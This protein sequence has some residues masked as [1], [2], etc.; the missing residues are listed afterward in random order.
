[1]VVILVARDKSRHCTHARSRCPEARRVLTYSGDSAV[2]E[3][4][5]VPV[6]PFLQ[7]SHDRLR[8]M[9]PQETAT[10]GICLKGC[11]PAAFELRNSAW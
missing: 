5:A 8:G 1:M 4:P 7:C 3:A 2:R 6:P 11:T 10:A 9:S